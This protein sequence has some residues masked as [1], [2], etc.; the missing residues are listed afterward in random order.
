MLS[1]NLVANL[2]IYLLPFIIFTSLYFIFFTWLYKF[3]SEKLANTY[4]ALRS[5]FCIEIIFIYIKFSLDYFNLLLEFNFLFNLLG[6]IITISFIYLLYTIFKTKALLAYLG[7]ELILLFS[8][9]I[10]ILTDSELAGGFSYSILLSIISG[11]LLLIAFFQLKVNTD[12]LNKIKL[13]PIFILLKIIFFIFLSSLILNFNPLILSD[14]LA[15]IG[16]IL[17]CYGFWNLKSDEIIYT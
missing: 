15:L 13:Y 5:V 10:P 8:S 16:I 7:I 12:R 14:F 4:F 3:K 11:I 6:Q 1:S 2:F 17:L 9:F